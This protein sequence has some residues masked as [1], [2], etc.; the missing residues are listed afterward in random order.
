M[1]AAAG[2]VGKEDR[3]LQW[4]CDYAGR[5][6]RK[7]DKRIFIGGSYPVIDRKELD[8]SLIWW[9]GQN[10][11]KENW[12]ICFFSTLSEKSLDL[13]TVIR[14]VN[15]LREKY[16]LIHLIIGGKG[17]GENYYRSLAADMPN[18]H[19][20]GWLNQEQMKSYGYF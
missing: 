12:N 2:I 4:G 15:V 10:V 14:A 11:L 3:S 16:P 7:T 1:S 5:S 19:F 20:A 8:E 13:E 18:I 17:D 9:R 6:E